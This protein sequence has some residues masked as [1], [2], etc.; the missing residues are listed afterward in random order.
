MTPR[1]LLAHVDRTRALVGTHEVC[2]A[3]LEMVGTVLETLITGTP[4]RIKA[5]PP[6]ALPGALAASAYA[7]VQHDVI[8]WLTACKER[9]L[10]E[11]PA[12]TTL[13]EQRPMPAWLD[14]ARRPRRPAHPQ[15][16]RIVCLTPWFPALL[17]VR[18]FAGCANATGSNPASRE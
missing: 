11:C 14:T 7:K 2:A 3:P 8:Y 17:L 9:A 6:R 15:G 16:A 13:S 5:P 18:F 10:R 1:D 12:L 4:A